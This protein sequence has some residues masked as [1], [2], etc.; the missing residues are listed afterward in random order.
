VISS[1]VSWIEK[2]IH[3]DYAEAVLYRNARCIIDDVE[4]DI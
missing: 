2:N 1:A 3:E 4:I